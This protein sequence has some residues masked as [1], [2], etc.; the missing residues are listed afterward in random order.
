MTLELSGIQIALGDRVLVP[1]LDARIAGGEVLAVM[2]PSGCGKSSLLN[3]L[4]GALEAPLRLSGQVRV[5]GVDVT[6]AP[7]EQRRIGLMLQDDWLFPHLT[8]LGNLLFAL[9]AD[10]AAGGPAARRARAEQAL[11]QAG[12]EGLGAHLPQELSGGQRARVA[13]WRTLLARPRAVL[14]DEPFAR[15]DAPLR[16]RTRAAVW[17]ALA[18]HA[19]PALIVT[20]DPQDVPPGAR[21]V[22]LGE[23]APGDAA[24]PGD[25]APQAAAAAGAA[26]SRDGLGAHGMRGGPDA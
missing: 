19:M 2:G 24:G 22:Q 18:E 26:R 14:L 15:L 3:G 25:P 17:Q 23:A 5:D 11:V 9:P 7:V 16:A 8:V 6:H 1:P 4:V 12:L 21:V 10:A 20:H 13:L